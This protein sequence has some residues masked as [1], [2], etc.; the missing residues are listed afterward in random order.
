MK[1]SGRDANLDLLRAVAVVSVILFH[2]RRLPSWPS[3]LSGF[4]LAAGG[5]AGVDLFFVL[6]G[7]LVGGLYWREIET[8]GGVRPLRFWARRALRTIP[9]YL[10]MLHLAWL[11][12]RGF[13]AGGGA[14]Y[15]P[16]FLLFLQNYDSGRMPYF[17]VSWSLCVEEHFYLLMLP[18]LALLRRVAGGPGETG[19]RG[20]A[21]VH[22]LFLAAALFS[23]VARMFVRIPEGVVFGY[24]STATH[25]RL[26]GLVLGVWIAWIARFDAPLHARL[27][28][29]ARRLWPLALARALA[30]FAVPHVWEVRGGYA[31]LALSFAT[32]LLAVEGAPPLARGLAGRVSGALALG[33][34]SLYLTHAHAIHVYERAIL[35]RAPAWIPDIL[36]LAAAL[37]TILATGAA[38]YLAVERPSI[39]AR[40]RIAP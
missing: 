37:A 23:P 35:P 22:L 17:L 21:R 29:L 10:V 19:G 27:R 16:R 13:G 12:K 26:E 1:P 7:R 40:D 39:R 3:W 4:D 20:E 14:A 8:A 34:Y 2:L 32:I 36:H 25:L 28:A 18:A 38:F 9:P 11:A 15:D 33:A 24:H 5:W 6:S 31:L 30:S